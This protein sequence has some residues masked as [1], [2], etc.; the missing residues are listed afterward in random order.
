MGGFLSED[1][2]QIGISILSVGIMTASRFPCKRAAQKPT[3]FHKMD[4]SRDEEINDE[5]EI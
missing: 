3:R 5:S 2:I 1:E 4:N